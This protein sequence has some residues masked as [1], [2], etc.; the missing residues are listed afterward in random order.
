MEYRSRITDRTRVN[1]SRAG[2]SWPRVRSFRLL[3][4]AAGAAIGFTLLSPQ[5]TQASERLPGIIGVDNRT[6]AD[7]N[8]LPW[9][10]IGRVNRETGGFC[11]GVLISPNEV[12][13]AAHCLWNKRA[14]RWLPADAIHFVTGWRGDSYTAHARAL[15]YELGRGISMSAQGRPNR[16][17]SD[18][19]V[20]TLD[21]AIGDKIG[22]VP[23]ATAQDRLG[24]KYA[25]GQA[26]LSTAAYNADRPNRLL[27]D[28]SCRPHQAA[29][30]GPILLHD[31]DL[32]YGTS[33][34]PLIIQRDGRFRVVGIQV[35]VVRNATQERGVA[36]M[37]QGTSIA[38][39]A[40]QW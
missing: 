28:R 7:I 14:A 11:T 12:L 40:M 10:A 4:V 6:P 23:M 15:S 29:E 32:T 27:S 26:V 8:R 38:A 2:I 25:A 18:W 22:Y 9:A 39:A 30:A 31:C 19:A 35:A 20:L 33:G 36:V 1:T 16:L 37:P 5:T 34:A 24:A 17:T 21:K 13:T 3:L